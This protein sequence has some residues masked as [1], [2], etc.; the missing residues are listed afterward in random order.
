MPPGVP[1]VSTTPIAISNT[2]IVT[3]L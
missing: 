3:I 1:P 2:T